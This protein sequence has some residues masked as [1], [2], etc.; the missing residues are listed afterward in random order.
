VR[1]VLAT[2]RNSL[3]RITT[4]KDLTQSGFYKS[5]GARIRELRGS[6][7][8]QEQLAR[9]VNLTRTSIVNIESGRQKLLVHNLFG[10][11]EALSVR[12]ADLIAPL[13]KTG[14]KIPSIKIQG[15]ASAGVNDWFQRSVSKARKTQ[16]SS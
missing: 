15:T 13:E 16:T 2:A 10:I 4:V 8:S 7:L 6:K 1:I 11:A 5:L 9:T 12:P 3:Q 14:D